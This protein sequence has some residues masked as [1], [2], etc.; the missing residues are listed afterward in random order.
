MHGDKF[1]SIRKRCLNLDFINHFRHACH[2]IFAGKN[3]STKRHQFGHRFSITGSFLQ[4]AA[5]KR[6]GFW[7]IQL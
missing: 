5:D 7:I 2:Y 3:G 6:N 1:G 4:L